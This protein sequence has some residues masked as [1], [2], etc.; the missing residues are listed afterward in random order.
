MRS[1]TSLPTCLRLLAPA[2]LGATLS[3]AQASAREALV[4]DAQAGED[5]PVAC[6]MNGASVTLDGTGSTV[7][8]EPAA[9]VAGATFAWEA[10]GVVFDDASSPTPTASF[11]PGTT[12]VT[13]TVTWQPPAEPFCFPGPPF[14]CPPDPFCELEP[15]LCPPDPFCVEDPICIPGIPGPPEI[16]Q[17]QVEVQVTDGTPPVISAVATPDVLRPPDHTLREIAVDI[18][19]EDSCSAELRI[20]LISLTSSEPDNAI[21]DGNSMADIQQAEL[22]ED[23]RHFLL[24]AERQGGGPGRVYTATYR[25]TDA[26]GNHSDAVAR[27]SVPHDK[28]SASSSPSNFTTPSN[29]LTASLQARKAAKAAAKA[30][31]RAHKQAARVARRAARGR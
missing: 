26:A 29:D 5:L 17:D 11:P 19:A 21:G 7:E 8:G 28:G 24:R 25:V 1:R 13:L 16:D 31:R 23:D 20:E 22:G 14:P 15:E 4:V 30:A 27:V 2:L 12:V 10:E 9:G 3:A 6:A 18:H